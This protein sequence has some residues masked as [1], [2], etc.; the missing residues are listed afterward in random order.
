M[1]EFFGLRHGINSNLLIWDTELAR[2]I[3]IIYAESVRN[4]AMMRYKEAVE[5]DETNKKFEQLESQFDA[6]LSE[7]Q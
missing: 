6:W 4:G 7:Q 2:T 1:I 3:Q 5:S